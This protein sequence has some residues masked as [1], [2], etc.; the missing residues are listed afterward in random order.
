MLRA[1]GGGGSSPAPRRPSSSGRG[2]SRS[3]GPRTGRRR[4]GSRPG[5]RRS[6]QAAGGL[7][8]ARREAAAARGWRIGE[9]G[10]GGREGLKR[11][12]EGSA[13]SRQPR[14]PSGNRFN[15]VS[16]LPVPQTTAVPSC[17]GDFFSGNRRVPRGEGRSFVSCYIATLQ[18]QLAVV[19]INGNFLVSDKQKKVSCRRRRNPVPKTNCSPKTLAVFSTENMSRFDIGGTV[20][21]CSLVQPYLVS[22]LPS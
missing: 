17:A 14:S 13:L 10:P 5:R 7:P 1:G 15:N 11:Q 20:W 9:A 6:P 4:G 16:G 19:L 2:W 8:S 18:Q 21:H 12:S 22:R 3:R